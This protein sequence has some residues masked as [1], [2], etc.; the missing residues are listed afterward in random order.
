MM[1]ME[2]TLIHAGLDALLA[3]TS[4]YSPSMT[5]RLSNVW[6]AQVHGTVPRGPLLLDP[7]PSWSSANISDL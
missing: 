7:A 4:G 1:W 2:G 3:P 5:S 6:V